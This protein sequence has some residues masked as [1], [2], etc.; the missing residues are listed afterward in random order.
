MRSA[1]QCAAGC[2]LDSFFLRVLSGLSPRSLRSSIFNRRVRKEHP[3]KNAEI[4]GK[5]ITLPL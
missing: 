1:K 3:Q 2:F 4:M 5:K